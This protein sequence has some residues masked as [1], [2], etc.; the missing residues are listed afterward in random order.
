MQRIA[1]DRAQE[2][3]VMVDERGRVVEV[4]EAG[5]VVEVFTGSQ[6][7]AVRLCSGGY[8]GWYY[9]TLAGERGRLALCMPV[10]QVDLSRVSVERWPLE[11][12]R[13]AWVG[14]WVQSRVPFALGMVRGVVEEITARGLVIFWY[15]RPQSPTFVMARFPVER[16]PELLE[17]VEVSAVA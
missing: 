17:P 1:F 4:L 14:Q 6:W 8:R 13:A 10:R 11:W 15:W 3:Y 12:V 9:E 16:L 2:R 5:V 7:Q